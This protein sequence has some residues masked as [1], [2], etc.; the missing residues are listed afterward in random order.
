VLSQSLLDALNE[1]MNKEFYSSYY[2]LSMSA[3]CESINLGGFGHWLRAQ[4]AE[5]YGHAL[6][7]YD[8]INSRG[9]RIVLK[10]VAQPPVEFQSPQDIFEKVLEH[11]R[12]VT[13]AINEL[14]AKAVAENDYATQTFLQWFINEQVEEEKTA[15]DIVE[16]VKMVASSSHGLLMLDRSLASR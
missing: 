8:Y 15:S 12:H 16:Q 4:S 14:Y 1:H 7:F 3:Y 9:G 2:Y 6:K 11:E 10:P 5:E 13:A